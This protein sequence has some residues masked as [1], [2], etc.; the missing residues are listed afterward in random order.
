MINLLYII[1]MAMLALNISSE[2]LEG[3]S[4][5]EESLLRTTASSSQENQMVYERLAQQMQA[6]PEKVRFWYE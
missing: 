4:I 5:V 1:L 3:F 6:N 2:V